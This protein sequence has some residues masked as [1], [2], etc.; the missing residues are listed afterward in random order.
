VKHEEPARGDE[1]E[2][3]DVVP[4]QRLAQVEHREDGEDASVMI[5]WIVFSST[6]VKVR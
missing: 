4:G 6:A 5:S 3:D 1:R 2:A